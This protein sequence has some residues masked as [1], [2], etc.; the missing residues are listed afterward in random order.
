MTMKTLLLLVFLLLPLNVLAQQE[1]LNA[2]LVSG[3]WYSKFPFFA[4]ETVR[5]YTAIQ[6]NSGDDLK[7]KVQF[8]KNNEPI[9]NAPFSALKGGLIQVWQDWQAQEG[10]YTISA[11]IVDATPPVSS[12]FAIAQQEVV[13]DKDTDKDNIGNTQDQDDDNDGLTDEKEQILGTDPLNPDTDGD[14]IKDGD[15]IVEQKAEEAGKENTFITEAEEQAE[16]FVGN[17]IEDLKTRQ[18]SVQ[19]RLATETQKPIL[20]LLKIPENTIPSKDALENLLLA[21]AITALPYWKIGV[22]LFGV[23]ILWKI[24]TR[25][26]F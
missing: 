20:R 18:E 19:E 10:T 8:S 24:I 7:G 11:R 25:F 3:I 21:A 13:V 17:I 16:T 5:I 26:V 2:G 9:G 14:Q 4:G 12:S 1:P 15:D 6:N 23:I 22:L